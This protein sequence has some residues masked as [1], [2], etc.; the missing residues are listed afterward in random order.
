M[1]RL[2]SRHI[3]TTHGGSLLDTISDGYPK[4]NFMERGHHLSSNRIEIRMIDPHLNAPLDQLFKDILAEG[5]DVFFHPHP[6]D[7]ETATQISHYEGKDVYCGL[8]AGDRI[9]GYGM[10][11]G[12][13]DGYDIP[14][15]GVYL[16]PFVRGNGWAQVLVTFLHAVGRENG[17]T[18]IRLT[19]YA[20]N[21]RAIKLY[22]KLGY[23]FMSNQ[24][25]QFIGII[26]L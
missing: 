25:S 14:S 8:V 20:S 10:L 7:S 1:G 13:D 4:L 11:R 18:K 23:N 9:L 15:L 19:V 22:Q 24:G 17:A 26:D 6:F 2:A 16:R 12:W 3:L 21:I 5:D